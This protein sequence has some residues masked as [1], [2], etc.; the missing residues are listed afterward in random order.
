[1]TIT[2]L[3]T[4]TSQGVPVIACNCEVCTSNDPHDKR[5]RTSVFIEVDGKNI[6][7]DSGP[8]FRFQMLRA[9][10]QH[11]D[12]I[13]FTHEHKDHTAG[14][15]DVRAFNYKQQE[16]MDVYA[17]ERVQT[18]LKREFAYVFEN[19]KY[20]GI[21]QLNLHTITTEPFYIGSLKVIPIEVLHYKL[22]VLGFRIGD[23]TYI[24]DAKTISDK[25]KEKIKGSK[26]LVINALQKQTHISHFTF[27]EAVELAQELGIEKTYFTHISHRL[28]R[29]HDISQELRPGIELAYDALQLYL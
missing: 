7:I 22:P 28:G 6:V 21:P 2:F 10:V 5:L 13:L 3:G 15:D 20:P 1:M 16:P 9:N 12:A 11:L 26:I 23:F 24:T 4:G 18:A 29:H 25:E 14:L 27:E 19:F 17:V 8:D